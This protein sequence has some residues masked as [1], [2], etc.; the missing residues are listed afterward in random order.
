VSASETKLGEGPADAPPGRPITT[1]PA[2]QERPQAEL[3]ELHAKAAAAWPKVSLSLEAFCQHLAACL[4]QDAEAAGSSGLARLHT[5][6]LYLACAAGQGDPAAID[7]VARE[8][9]RPIASSLRAIENSG[10]VLDE[11][12]QRLHERLLLPTEGPRRILQYAGRSSL[13][14]WVGVAAQRIAL[15]L[16]RAE[17]THRRAAE[18]A[19]EER[20]DPALDPELQY[21]KERYRPD[22][23]VA[24]AAAI[25]RLPQRERTAVRLHTVGGLSLAKIGIMFGVNEST[26]SRWVQ[27]ARQTILVETQRELGKRLGIRLSDVPS[28]VRLVTSQLDVSLA[29]MLDSEEQE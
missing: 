26:A 11:V 8:F 12:R 16:L 15:D 4:A 6:D 27:R 17:S 19:A 14:T 5:G 22:F 24:L 3:V 21:L 25:A 2:G 7:A 10:A 23:S 28:L 9:V 29:R 20:L 13:A 1:D 18:R